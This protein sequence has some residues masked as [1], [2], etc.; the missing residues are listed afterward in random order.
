MTIR[1]ALSAADL[2]A[3]DHPIWSAL[4][5]G[6]RHLAIGDELARRYPID[7]S[8]FAAMRDASPEAYAALHALLP[9]EHTAF[10][11]TT[12]PLAPPANLIVQLAASVNQ[13]VATRPPESPSGRHEFITLTADD[14]PDML[15][16]TALTKPGPF[17]A[18]TIELGTYLGVRTNGQLV[19]MAG[20]RM[21]LAG[22]VEVSAVCV[23][24][25]HRGHGYARD[26]ILT[27]MQRQFAQGAVPMLH[28][29]ADNTPAVALYESMGFAVR[30]TLSFTGLKRA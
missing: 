9:P 28:T 17:A 5:T 26:L 27:L 23:H 8:P 13:M 6:H 21:R 25:D 19:A 2:V 7:V 15:A 22:Q 14:V 20:E 30:Q 11:C 24:P 29:Y 1:Y 12:E 3:L 18:R 4:Q 10:L 16:L